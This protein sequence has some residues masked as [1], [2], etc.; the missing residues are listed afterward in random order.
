MEPCGL[1]KRM[2]NM[3]QF[4]SDYLRFFPPRVLWSALVLNNPFLSI[5]RYH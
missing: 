5:P 1:L 2:R 4:M 3:S